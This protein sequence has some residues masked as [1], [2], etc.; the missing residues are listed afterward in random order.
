MTLFKVQKI[1]EIISLATLDL[2][3]FAAKNGLLA[4]RDIEKNGTQFLLNM[5]FNEVVELEYN[6]LGK[7]LIKGKSEHISISHSHDK[8]AIIVNAV[9]ETGVDIEQIR[10]K[11]LKIKNKFLSAD[12]LKAANDSVE[13]LIIYWACKEALYKIYGLKEVE[14]IAHLHIE[15]F[16]LKE[17]GTIKGRIKMENFDKKYLLHYEKVEDYMLVYILNEI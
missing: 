15:N 16:D 14:F 1:N 6:S 10:D 3:D 13:K 9:T 17:S 11:V 5:L 7:P 8:L 4:K 2:P 12:E